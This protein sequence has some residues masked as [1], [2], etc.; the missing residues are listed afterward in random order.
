MEKLNKPTPRSFPCHDFTTEDGVKHS[1]TVVLAPISLKLEDG[2]LKI[3]WACSRAPYCHDIYCRYSHKAQLKH[4][5]VEEYTYE[6][7]VG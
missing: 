4:G 6:V 5:K 1:V 2:A 3:G 7:E